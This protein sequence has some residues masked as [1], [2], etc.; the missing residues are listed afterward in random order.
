MGSQWDIFYSWVYSWVNL[1]REWCLVTKWVNHYGYVSTRRIVNAVPVGANTQYPLTIKTK[2]YS[3]SSADTCWISFNMKYVGIGAL[4]NLNVLLLGILCN[5]CNTITITHYWTTMAMTHGSARMLMLIEYVRVSCRLWTNR[6]YIDIGECL[7]LNL[8]LCGVWCKMTI[9][10]A[11]SPVIEIHY[12]GNGLYLYADAVVQSIWNGII[13]T[14][15]EQ[16]V[17]WYWYMFEFQYVSIL[18]TMC[19][20]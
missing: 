4:L 16:K 3:T 14:L 19:N 20:I 7:N 18:Y 15:D 1:T 9:A 2:N 6:K 17:R 12:N 13:L 11:H 10:I 8:S 5:I